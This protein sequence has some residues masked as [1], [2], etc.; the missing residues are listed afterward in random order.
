M[1]VGPAQGASKNYVARFE[2]AGLDFALVGLH[3]LAFPDDSQRAP[4]R[5]SQA[6]VI[7]RLCVREGTGRRRFLIVLG[8]FNDFDPRVQ[9]VAGN[10]T[11]TRVLELIRGVD[12]GTSRDDL[13]NVASTLPPGERFSAFFDRDRDG[14]DD[15]ITERSLTDHILISRELA[16]AIETVEVFDEHDPIEGPSDHFPLKLTLDL[17][18]LEL[19]TRGDADSDGR[20]GWQDAVAILDFLFGGPRLACVDS[21]DTDDDGR[22]RVTDA[23]RLLI[24]VF[25]RGP[26][27][28]PPGSILPGHDPTDDSLGCVLRA[29]R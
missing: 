10:S 18:R 20:L 25:R 7:R 4:R 12:D 27:P 17:R 28:P 24:H 3:L 8:D 16:P 21:A 14:F 11:R 19:F 1:F 5:E 29:C 15:G 26:A 13:E 23:I 2:V 22:I 9:D 6:E